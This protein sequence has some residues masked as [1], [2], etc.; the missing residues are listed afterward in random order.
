MRVFSFISYSAEASRKRLGSPTKD[1]INER[2]LFLGLDEARNK[3]SKDDAG[4]LSLPPMPVP[5]LCGRSPGRPGPHACGG[6]RGAG[7]AAL[8]PRH[9]AP[10]ADFRH[11]RGAAPAPMPGW[12]SAR[13]P[14]W[15]P[16]PPARSGTDIAD[17]QPLAAVVRDAHGTRLPSGLDA[18]VAGPGRGRGA[19]AAGPLRTPSTPRRADDAHRRLPRSQVAADLPKPRRNPASA[20]RA[21]PAAPSARGGE[22]CGHGYARGGGRPPERTIGSATGRTRPRGTPWCRA[23]PAPSRGEAKTRPGSA[24]AAHGLS[25]GRATAESHRAES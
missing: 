21:R 17:G 20:R 2:S 14:P 24:A 8:A 22:R 4:P 7:F 23:V 19:R 6:D 9:A 1:E 25:T 5:G 15:L 18:D 10:C 16:G 11:G 12:P 3:R 13:T